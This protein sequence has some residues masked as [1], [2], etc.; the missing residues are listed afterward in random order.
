LSNG[1]VHEE[2]AQMA[3]VS[4]FIFILKMNSSLKQHIPTMAYPSFASPSHSYFAYSQ[5]P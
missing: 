2:F 1:S 3:M 4:F 5:D